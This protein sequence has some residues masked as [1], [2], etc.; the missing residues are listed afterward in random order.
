M[1]PRFSLCAASLALAL[2]GCATT[3]KSPTT[4]TTPAKSPCVSASLHQSPGSAT[5]A[6]AGR[7]YSS[8]DLRRTGEIDLGD[9]LQ[10]LDPAI[11]VHH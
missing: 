11:T 9:A 2:A 10:K 4:A 8:E 6:A 1:T 3:P 7:S 5:C